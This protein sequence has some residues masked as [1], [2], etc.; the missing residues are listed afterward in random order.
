MTVGWPAEPPRIRPRLPMQ[1]ILHWDHYQ[2]NQDEALHAYDRE[3][4]E[5]GI[6][7]Q[8]QVPVPGKPDVMENYGWLEHTARRV[9]RVT[10]PELRAILEEQGFALR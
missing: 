9:S 2:G 7:D 3:M 10:R 8:R 5:T 1:A 6:Y 4:A